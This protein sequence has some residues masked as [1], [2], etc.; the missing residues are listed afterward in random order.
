MRSEL[1]KAMAAAYALGDKA[2]PRSHDDQLNP[3]LQPLDDPARA[4]A[5]LA[6]HAAAHPGDRTSEEIRQCSD[7]LAKLLAMPHHR[8]A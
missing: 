6:R 1:L 8:Q 7:I 5:S 3:A 4:L 2:I